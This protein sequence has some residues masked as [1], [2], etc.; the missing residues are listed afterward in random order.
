MFLCVHPYHGI[1]NDYLHFWTYRALLIA[2]RY[3]QVIK[4]CPVVYGKI[5]GCFT[6]NVWMLYQNAHTIPV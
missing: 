5:S 2:D 6:G 3:N 4:H 1:E